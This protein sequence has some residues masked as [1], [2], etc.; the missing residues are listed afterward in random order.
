M[1]NHF[2]DYYKERQQLETIITDYGFITYGIHNDQALLSDIYVAPEFRHTDKASTLYDLF[3]DHAKQAGCKHVFANFS[4]AD[5]ASSKN[6][7]TC[8]RRGFRL[9]GANNQ[10]ITVCKE[11]K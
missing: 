4:V 6:L 9:V 7:T 8:L 3:Y 1:T 5:Q 2:A 10:Q 11:I